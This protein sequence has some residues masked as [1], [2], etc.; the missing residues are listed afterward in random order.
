MC[1]NSPDIT[2]ISIKSSQDISA[3]LIFYNIIYTNH[4]KLCLVRT[5]MLEI[6]WNKFKKLDFKGENE[7]L[8]YIYFE[9]KELNLILIINS[10]IGLWKRDRVFVTNKY[11]CNHELNKHEIKI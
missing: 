11:R 10:E 1:L 3:Q 2:I 8:I 5:K 9:I 6:S 4:N 7:I